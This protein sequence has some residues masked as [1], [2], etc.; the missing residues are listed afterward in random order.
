MELVAKQRVGYVVLPGYDFNQTKKV[1]DIFKG[2][3]NF[4]DHP[5]YRYY[6]LINALKLKPENV[7]SWNNSEPN[8]SLRN[9][10]IS[11]ALRP[12]RKSVV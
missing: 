1:W 12:D 5:Q 2:F 7:K 8:T 11:L 4:E 6:K 9:K 3:E 10:F